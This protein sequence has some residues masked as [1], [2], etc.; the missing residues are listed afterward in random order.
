MVSLNGQKIVQYVIELDNK[1]QT[2]YFKRSSLWGPSKS[3][4]SPY[5]K[6]T[7]PSGRK[8]GNWG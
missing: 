5:R 2:E 4:G 6:H 1:R 3:F 7:I 8:G